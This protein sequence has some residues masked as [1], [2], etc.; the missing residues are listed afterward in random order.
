MC[1]DCSCVYGMQRYAE[2]AAISAGCIFLQIMQQ[3]A[4]NASICKDCSNK[5]RIHLYINMYISKDCIHMLLCTECTYVHAV[6]ETGT[7]YHFGTVCMSIVQGRDEAPRFPPTIGFGIKV[8]R[9]NVSMTRSSRIQTPVLP[10]T[11]PS[12]RNACLQPHRSSLV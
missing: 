11:L 12:R 9:L 2:N 8:S 6:Q 7:V 4:P 5:Y 1:I 3:Q 10:R